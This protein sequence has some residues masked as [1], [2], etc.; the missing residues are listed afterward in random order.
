M[1][2][3]QLKIKPNKAQ[4]NVCSPSECGLNGNCEITNNVAV[5]VCRQGFVGSKCQYE[6][7]C[8]VTKRPCGANGACFPIIQSQTGQV[9]EQISY[10]CQCYSGF[11]GQNC[12]FG[13]DK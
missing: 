1:K 8:S 12:E 6:D 9:S 5:C 13:K 4:S 10:H 11:Y 2:I 7:P 3:F